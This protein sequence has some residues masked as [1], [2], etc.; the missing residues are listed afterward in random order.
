VLSEVLAPFRY[1]FPVRD[2][3]HRLKYGGQ[4][5]LGRVFGLLLAEHLAG[6][7]ITYDLLVP[8]PLHRTRL[9]GRGYNQ[10]FEIARTLRQETGLP[11]LLAGMSR[12][13][14]T[15]P[16]AGLSGGARRANVRGAF[17]IA[18]AMG[19][20]E[21]LVVDDVITTGATANELARALLRA[22][23]ASVGLAAVARS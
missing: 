22:G 17:R 4:R 16:Q 12:I 15:L 9:I 14:A 6:R 8:M 18:R 13:R 2:L 1:A 3:L 19:G 21:V 11:V 23:A 7:G 10:S 20:A 5:Q